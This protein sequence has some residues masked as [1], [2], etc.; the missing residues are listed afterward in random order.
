[1]GKIVKWPAERFEQLKELVAQELTSYQI[2]DILGITRHAVLGKAWRNGLHLQGGARAQHEVKKQD[3]GLEPKKVRRKRV[4][5]RQRQH[6]PRPKY[7]LT[8][9]DVGA[10]CH[11]FQLRYGHCRWP[12]WE[13]TTPFEAKKFCGQRAVK[14][15]SYCA[16]H[17]ALVFQPVQPRR[18]R[19]L[20]PFRLPK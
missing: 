9:A 10:S 20:A 6:K 8:P 16:E 11:V 3:T 2:A 4:R 17:A 14:G 13:L 15:S 18:N 5:K 12:L 1:M 19:A 7:S